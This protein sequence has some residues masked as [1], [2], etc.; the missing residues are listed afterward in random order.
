MGT[1]DVFG[2]AGSLAVILMW[3]YYSSAVF[4]FGAEIAREL[5]EASQKRDEN[6]ATDSLTLTGRTVSGLHVV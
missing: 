1:T 5:A 3:L 6:G 4:L 2:A